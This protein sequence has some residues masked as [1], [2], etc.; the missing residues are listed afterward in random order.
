MAQLKEVEKNNPALSR[1]QEVLRSAS[2]NL[3]FS[4]RQEY[5]S[6]AFETASEPEVSGELR[7]EVIASAVPV[8]EDKQ[9]ILNAESAGWDDEMISE[10]VACAGWENERFEKAAGEAGWSC[11]RIKGAGLVEEH[12]AAF[13]VDGFSGARANR[14]K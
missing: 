6:I 8:F 5:V 4:S 9:I 2:L 7:A 3:E 12:N 10:A 14:L 11:T 13:G 1:L